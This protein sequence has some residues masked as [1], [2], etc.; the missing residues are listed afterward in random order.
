ML[1][2][3]RLRLKVSSLVLV[4]SVSRYYIHTVAYSAIHRVATCITFDPWLQYH[5]ICKLLGL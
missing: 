3:S 5:N 2:G 4:A 1:L